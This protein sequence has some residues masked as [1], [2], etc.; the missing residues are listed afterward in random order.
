MFLIPLYL[1]DVIEDTYF[2]LI[3]QNIPHHI[4]Q[5]LKQSWYF[6]YVNGKINL[7]SSEKRNTQKSSEWNIHN[8]TCFW[9]KFPFPWVPRIGNK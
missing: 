6:I 5:V 7:M 1:P 4:Q 3:F 8:C 2:M 9:I